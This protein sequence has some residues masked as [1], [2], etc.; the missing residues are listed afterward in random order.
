MNEYFFFN[1]CVLFFAGT[2]FFIKE[3][4]NKMRQSSEIK[5]RLIRDVCCFA[6][7]KISV[8]AVQFLFSKISAVSVF[9]EK[10]TFRPNK[11]TI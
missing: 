8:F 1:F 5:W 9:H 3:E 2:S 4:K 11:G 7:C 10:G 6:V